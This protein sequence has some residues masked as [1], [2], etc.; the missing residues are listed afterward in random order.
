LL[1]PILSHL[2]RR[3]PLF[4]VCVPEDYDC[5]RAATADA[6]AQA[7]AMIG[8]LLGEDTFAPGSLRRRSPLGGACRPERRH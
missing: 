6:L 4:E 2:I 1:L 8:E 3:H 5:A 7:Q